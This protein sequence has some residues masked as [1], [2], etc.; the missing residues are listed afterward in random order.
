MVIFQLYEDRGTAMSKLMLSFI[1]GIK[2][3]HTLQR[4]SNWPNYHRLVRER[5]LNT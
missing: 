3:R 4:T 1:D 5:K 2:K